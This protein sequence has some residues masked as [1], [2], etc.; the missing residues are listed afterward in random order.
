MA[1]RFLRLKEVIF[2]SGLG[3]SSIYK[4][5]SEGKFPPPVAIGE[6]S[7]GWVESEFENWFE[8]KLAKRASTSKR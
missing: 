7:I 2:R 6:R 4:L 1:K 8:L 5:V 3:R